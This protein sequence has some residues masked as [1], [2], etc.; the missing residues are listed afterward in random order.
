MGGQ[1]GTLI[2]WV[3][4][5]TKVSPREKRLNSGQKYKCDYLQKDVFHDGEFL[6]VP[7]ISV[8]NARKRK[9]GGT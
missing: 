6:D 9:G 8:T 3:T 5:S 4:G 1:S 7:G 2:H